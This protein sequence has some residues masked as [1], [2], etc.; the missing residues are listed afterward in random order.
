VGQFG[1]LEAAD[2]PEVF[3]AL[4]GTAESWLRERGMA[5]V[6]GPFSLNIN[7]ETGLLVDG[8]DTPPMMLMPHDS[9]YAGARLEQQGYAKAKDVFA[10]LYDIEGEL[11]PAAAAMIRRGLPGN[12]RLRPLDMKRYG[13]ELRSITDIFN[14]AWSQNWGFVPWTEADTKHLGEALRLLVDKRLVWFAEVDGEP[15]AFIVCLPNLNEA[16]R[17]LGGS[18]LPFGWAK[19]VW[20]LKVS[21]VRTARVPL[22]GVRRRYANSLVGALLPFLIIDAVRREARAKGFRQIELSWILED[23]LPMRRII[24]AIGGRAYKTY[25]VYSKSLARP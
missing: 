18:L 2:D 10:Y 16:I 12:V 25:R 6:Q 7:E 17:D 8:F 4:T 11:P 3:A 14:D 24:E 22:M 19:A 1:L 13:E 15:A 5:E 23:N 21:G 20:R 9:R